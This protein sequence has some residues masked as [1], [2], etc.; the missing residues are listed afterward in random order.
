MMKKQIFELLIQKFSVNKKMEDPELQRKILLQADVETYPQLCGTSPGLRQLCLSQQFWEEKFEQHG[1]TLIEPQNS[2]KNYIIAFRYCQDTLSLVDE[3]IQ[4]LQSRSKN[5][6]L[7]LNTFLNRVDDFAV[8]GISRD[9]LQDIWMDRLSER[10]P[11]FRKTVASGAPPVR[12]FYSPEDQQ[13]I[14]QVITVA[15][16]FRFKIST[17]TLRTL[18]YVLSYRR[19]NFTSDSVLTTQFG[20]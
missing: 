17:N 13:F 4:Q 11:S 10:Q 15:G 2:I 20:Y 7:I 19:Y 5:R 18:L 3:T 8:Q 9:D 14:F 1:L 12:I 16:R 6:T